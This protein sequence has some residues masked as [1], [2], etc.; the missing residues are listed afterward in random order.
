MVCVANWTFHVSRTVPTPVAFVALNN[1]SK[2]GTYIHF[3]PEHGST[4]RASLVAPVRILHVGYK[5]QQ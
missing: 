4:I 5:E 2:D 1:F 3:R